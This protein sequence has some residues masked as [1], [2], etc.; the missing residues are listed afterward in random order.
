MYVS[1]IEMYADDAIVE[2]YKAGFVGRFHGHTCCV[3]EAYRALLSRKIDGGEIWK[4]ICI[5]TDTIAEPPGTSE[6]DATD[7]IITVSWP[8]DFSEYVASDPHAKKRLILEAI[9]A[10]C[11]WTA[12]QRGWDCGPFETA[13]ETILG[14]DLDF[15]GF[16][17]KSWVSPSKKY[18]ARIFFEF[19][20][21]AVKLTAVLFKNRTKQEVARRYLG[22]GI[23]TPGCL[24]G[25]LRIGKWNSEN[26]FV[27]MLQGFWAK[28]LTADFSDVMK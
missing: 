6:Y 19:Q 26:E 18:R 14:R 17:K 9:N 16:S 15:E 8:F 22:K 2:R 21:E 13:Y 27:L 23:P 12:G 25:F 11:L 10:A 4:I 28:Q 24:H 20:L 3:V 5:G 7:G 1:D